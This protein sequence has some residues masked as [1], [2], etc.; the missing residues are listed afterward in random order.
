MLNW[1]INTQNTES[2]LKRLTPLGDVTSYVVDVPDTKQIEATAQQ[3]K[4]E[5]WNIIWKHTIT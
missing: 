3:L 1:G 5:H 2:T 4:K